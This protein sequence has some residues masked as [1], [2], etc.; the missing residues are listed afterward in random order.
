MPTSEQKPTWLTTAQK[1]NV[2]WTTGGW[3]RNAA[4]EETGTDDIGADPELLV[5]LNTKGLTA[6]AIAGAATTTTTT[7]TKKSKSKSKAEEDC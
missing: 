7:T 6:P 2:T 1:T 3:V 5:A 4:S